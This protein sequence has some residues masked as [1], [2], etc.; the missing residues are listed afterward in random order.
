MSYINYILARSYKNVIYRESHTHTHTHTQVV[1]E[2]GGGITSQGKGSSSPKNS[3]YQ[4]HCIVTIIVFKTRFCWTLLRKLEK[5]D[6]NS[7]YGRD[8]YRL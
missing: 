6:L 3:Y 7:N 4:C 1:R 5:L 8:A 2:R